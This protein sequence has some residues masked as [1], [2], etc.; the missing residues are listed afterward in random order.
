MKKN[1]FEK[2]QNR[3]T[4]ETMYDIANKDATNSEKILTDTQND[5]DA[6]NFNRQ[7]RRL[8]QIRQETSDFNLIYS[9]HLV[10]TIIFIVISFIILSS[11]FL[12]K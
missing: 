11:I 8:S 1:V 3:P 5:I 9:N 12:M 4:L 7:R 10:M 2:A 6:I